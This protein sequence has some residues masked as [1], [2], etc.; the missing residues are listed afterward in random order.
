MT[1]VADAIEA[2]SAQLRADLAGVAERIQVEET[3]VF[4]RWPAL[5]AVARRRALREMQAR[6]L[7]LAAS[8]GEIA[9]VS[10]AGVVDG[11][12]RLGA[13][14]T[15]L[16]AG[17]AP[18][19]GGVDV[20]AIAALSSD[21][22]G[23]V[24]EATRHVQSSTKDLVRALARERIADKL[25]TG[26]TPEQAS[27]LLRRDFEGRGI[28]AIVYKD[29]SRHGLGDYSEMIVRT[30]SA[31]AGQL[32]GFAQART[33][34]VEFMEIM[35][36]PGCGLASHQDPR[37]ANGLILPLAEAEQFPLSHPRCRRTTSARPDIDAATA[38]EARPLGPQFTAEQIQ[39]AHLD[40]SVD[41]PASKAVSRARARVEKRST[42][43]TL[44]TERGASAA[45]RR[46]ATRRARRVTT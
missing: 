7:A 38:A 12:Y 35:D 20:D 5:T 46:N 45:E 4:D 17:A 28:T 10:V 39:A 37:K 22:Y 27:R 44:R 14:Q 26:Q 8:A 33:I 15:A 30:K 19:F 1:T 29:G 9:R 31:E 2:L 32:G 23:D 13:G 25:V 42:N 40:S 36:G 6:V 21:A 16:T 3:T 34:G 24:L 41:T 43:G 11:A 18:V